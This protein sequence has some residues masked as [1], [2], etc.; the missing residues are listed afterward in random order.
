MHLDRNTLTS[1][2]LLLAIVIGVGVWVIAINLLLEVTNQLLDTL[3][4]IVEIA[5]MS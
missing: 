3:Q 2:S 4:Y 5:Q 1:L